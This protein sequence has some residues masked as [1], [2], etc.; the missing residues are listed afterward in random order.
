MLDNSRC[1]TYRKRPDGIDFGPVLIQMRRRFPFCLSTVNI[2]VSNRFLCAVIR[3]LVIGKFLPPHQGHLA[4]I[5]FGARQCDELIV[6]V[7][8]G[9]GYA[10]PTALRLQWLTEL[11]KPW[12]HVKVKPLVDDFDDSTLPWDQ[13]T[14]AWA[15]AINLAYGSIDR[16]FSSEEYGEAFARNLGAQHVTFDR[17]R[18]QVPVSASMI[19][20]KPFRH[21]RFIPPVVRPYFVKKICF[22]GAESTG[23]STIAKKMAARYQTVSVPEVAREMITSNDFTVDDIIRIGYAQTQRVVDMAAVANK[24]LFCDTDVI[25]TEVYSQHYL[26]VTPEVLF[27]LEKQVKYD[28]YFFLDIDVPWVADGLRGLGDRRQEMSDRFMTELTR[29]K[30]QFITV[31]GSFEERERVIT[32]EIDRLIDRYS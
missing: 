29:R 14:K 4:L 28:L 17:G 25:T 10:I 22:F 11:V 23:K 19:R 13:R 21:W 5:A 15:T 2:P 27:D 7:S 16:V 12:P 24:V 6:S 3:G 1:P 9:E 32:Q 31:R 26:G 18:H 8:A 30:I 20:E